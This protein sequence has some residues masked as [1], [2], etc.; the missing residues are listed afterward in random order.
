[1]VADYFQNDVGLNE[2]QLRRRDPVHVEKLPFGVCA[3]VLGWTSRF[4]SS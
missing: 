1:M 3:G 4:V 2:E